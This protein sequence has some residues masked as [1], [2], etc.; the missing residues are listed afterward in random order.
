MKLKSL[1]AV[2]LAALL[3]MMGLTGFAVAEEAGEEVSAGVAEVQA[4]VRVEVA[5]PMAEGGVGVGQ[6]DAFLPGEVPD[7][8][9][10]GG[11]VSVES[12]VASALVRRRAENRNAVVLP[13]ETDDRPEIRRRFGG[14]DMVD[15]VVGAEGLDGNLLQR[16]LSVLDDPNAGLVPGL[17]GV[18]VEQSLYIMYDGR[19]SLRSG[20]ADHVEPR[21]RRSVIQ[22]GDLGERRPDVGHGRARDRS[23]VTRLRNAAHRPAGYGVVKI[24]GLEVIPLAY[25]QRAGH[26]FFTVRGDERYGNVR[27]PVDAGQQSLVRQPVYKIAEFETM[28]HDDPPD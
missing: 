6:G 24:L 27:V 25:E 7:R 17:F 13:A 19:F 18:P 14:I 21:A 12:G 1:I 10:N 2:L 16:N 9:G 28:R 20:D 23:S 11:G 3:A 15:G 8:A 5:V 4:V 26:G 22:V